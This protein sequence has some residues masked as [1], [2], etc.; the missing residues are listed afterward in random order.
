MTETLTIPQAWRGL[1]RRFWRALALYAYARWRDPTDKKMP[2]GVP[3]NRDP[4]AVCRAYVPGCPGDGECETDGHY[5][6]RTDPGCIRA[7][8]VP[9]E[10]AL[11]DCGHREGRHL[12]CKGEC[13]DCSCCEFMAPAAPETGDDR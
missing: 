3:G 13:G 1:T 12:Q 11:C 2:V 5:L 10:G 6:C 9:D 8:A 4:G 7:C